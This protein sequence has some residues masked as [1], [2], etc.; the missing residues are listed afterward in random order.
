MGALG[1]EPKTF[2]LRD[3]CST[4]ELCIIGVIGFEPILMDSKSTALP[5]GYTTKKKN[6]KYA[7]FLLNTI[8]VTWTKHIFPI[9]Y[10]RINNI[11]PHFTH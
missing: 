7:T 4:I 2:G 5:F 1:F 11:D 9:S 6:T 10:M 8:K 3:H